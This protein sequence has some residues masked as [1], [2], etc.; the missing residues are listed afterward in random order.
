MFCSKCGGQVADSAAFCPACGQP[1]GEQPA[2]PRGIPLAPSGFGP[3]E[4]ANAPAASP[5]SPMQQT[6]YAPPVAARSVS[7]P[8]MAYAGF[9]LRF[10][11]WIIDVFLL[12][13]VLG[14]FVFAPLLG[15]SLANMEP[16]NFWELLNTLGPKMQEAQL[17]TIVV[18]WLYYALMES[19]SWQG[20]VGKK[21]LG[22][23]ATDLNGNRLTF[24]RATGRFF[25]KILSFPVTLGIGYIMAGFTAKKQALHD[26]IAGCLVMRK[27]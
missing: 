25:G 21:A 14:M 3:S 17:I 27:L 13:I 19:S 6:V 22:L 15:S 18:M 12:D 8:G 26:L 7:F 24:G 20:T 10:V 1:T 11:A 4:S 16:G 2:P 5:V 23:V 9:W